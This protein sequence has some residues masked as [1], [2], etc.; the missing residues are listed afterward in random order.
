M[1][2]KI[3]GSLVCPC[4]KEKMSLGNEGKSLICLGA[5]RHCFD[6]SS[7][8]YVNLSPK[9]SGGGDSKSAVRSRSRFLDSGAYEP[10]S[11]AMNETLAEYLPSGGL[12]IDAGCGE[13]YYSCRMAAGGASVLGID[14][15]KEGVTSAAKRA[16]RNGRDNTLF[17]VASVFEIPVADGTADAVVN[18]FAPCAETEYRR[19]LRSGGKLII[20]HAGPEHLMGLKR[21]LYESVY[22]NEARAD[23]PEGMKPVSER[24]IK[25]EISLSSAEQISDLFAMTPYYWRTSVSDKDKLALLDSLCTEVDVIISVYEKN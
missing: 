15:S 13:G 10:V 4:C 14:L 3:L 22:E 9:H 2:E 19:V 5:R 16:K 6:I 23:M 24:R 25:Y 21:V 7:S 12:V 1:D 17:G 8:G 11:D 20:A 18:I